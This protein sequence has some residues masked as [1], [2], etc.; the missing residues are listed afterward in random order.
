MRKYRDKIIKYALISICA[1]IILLL[2][3]FRV[4]EIFELQTIDWRFQLRPTFN[5]SQKIN[6]DIVIIEISNYDIERIG[7]WPFERL[8]HANLIEALKVAGA[9]MA[10]FDILFTEPS[11]FDSQLI[12]ATANYGKVYY[13]Y[14]FIID[15]T[16]R[17][18][19]TA[20]C[21]EGV[22]I[23][24][25][26]EAAAGSG[27]INIIPDID[28]KY[29]KIPLYIK[30]NDKYYPQLTLSA[31]KDYYKVLDKDVTF[32]HGNYI[33]LADKA[34]IP[35]NNRNEII[36]NYID[37]WGGV[38]KH[39]SFVDILDAYCYSESLKAI[40][41]KVV[42]LKDLEG[43]VCYV[44]LT[45]TGL[46][47]MHPAPVEERYPGVGA[48]LNLFN[49]ITTNQYV[50]RVERWINVLILLGLT[51]L[52]I[53][54]SKH[55]IY[56]GLLLNVTA[57]AGFIVLGFAIFIYLGIWI[58]LF[59]PV[60]FSVILYL[61]MTFYGLIAEKH[62]SEI[63]GKEL[64]VARR[65]QES[66]LPQKP[67]EIEGY[68]VAAN[69][70]AAKQVGGDL[71]Q[72]IKLSNEKFGIMIADVSGKGIPAALYMVRIVTEFKTWSQGID[73]PD[74][75]LKK[76]NNE[77]Q[78]GAKAGLFVT[79]SYPIID[80]KTKKVILSDGGH[81]PLMHYR[82]KED[83]IVEERPTKGMPL[84]LIP[85][86]EFN[87]KEFSLSAGDVLV[88]YTDGVSEARN[89][90]KEEYGFQR[91]KDVTRTNHQKDAAGILEALRN[92]IT[93]FCGKAPQHDDITIIV[94]KVT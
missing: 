62:R 41:E 46:F 26:S 3:Y 43:K 59:Y 60:S 82:A 38:Y 84:G 34:K 89:L 32:S 13:P 53:V 2:S 24:S 77:L 5:K 68:D 88:F 45:A 63:M 22:I 23:K 85:N 93:E 50:I 90:K 57:I 6:P 20:D 48:H 27:H 11:A 91:I 17:G 9:K 66:F 28:G 70:N 36:I 54:L 51:I 74:E 15:Y 30:D 49:S 40:D 21:Q 61:G 75:V 76:L 39:Y 7:S 31:V 73:K 19:V 92:D 52:V 10:I 29:R 64:E 33:E 86:V 18:E 25:L 56:K 94:L 4:F 87:E 67:I 14:S 72:F 37:K 58:D 47:D 1:L 81:L 80:I 65:I 69:M 71:Y 79:V 42:D 35:I 8:Y 55:S 12:S 16:K 44:A 78:K 83:E